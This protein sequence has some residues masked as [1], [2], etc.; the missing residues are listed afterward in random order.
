MLGSAVPE[1]AVPIIRVMR[2]GGEKGL[3][4]MAAQQTR[5]ASGPGSGVLLSGTVPPLADAYYP[6]SYTHL[7]LPT[8]REV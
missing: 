2:S 4:T 7:T 5:T 1:S 3:F 6:V 8:N